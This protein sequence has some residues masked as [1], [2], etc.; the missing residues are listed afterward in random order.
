MA[1]SDVMTLFKQFSGRH[2]LF[3]QAGL[4]NGALRFL[5]KAQRLLDNKVEDRMLSHI[6]SIALSDWTKELSYIIALEDIWISDADG[7]V[8]ME[9]K[10]LNW[11][12]AMY[13]K[14][15]DEL[16]E[17]RPKYFTLAQGELHPDTRLTQV[18][19]DALHDSGD[20]MNYEGSGSYD[21]FTKQVLLWYPPADG[22]YTMRIFG[23]FKSQTLVYTT[24]P[25]VDIETYWTEQHE[26]LLVATALMI[27][28]MFY[29][30]TQGV[31]DYKIAHDILFNDLDQEA[32][33]KE[34][35]QR[36]HIRG[37]I[38]KYLEDIGR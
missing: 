3:T 4:D 37:N 17:G 25:A 35:V 20:L 21:G 16:T 34:I 28:E 14:D 22:T 5:N 36:T 8:Q 9:K 6:S 30:N 12:R 32:T 7:R 10:D 1:T 33:S 26:L 23:R 15:H 11:L 38:Y 18:Q 24:T 2:D 31:S 27:V 13:S 29:R 19:L